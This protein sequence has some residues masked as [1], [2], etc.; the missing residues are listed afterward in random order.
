MPKYLESKLLSQITVIELRS[1]Q[2]PN[3]ENLTQYVQTADD[4]SKL[5]NVHC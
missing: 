3:L 2:Q 5:G 4:V 1:A